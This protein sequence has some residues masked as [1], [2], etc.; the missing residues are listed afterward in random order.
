MNYEQTIRDWIDERM[1]DGMSEEEAQKSVI[2]DTSKLYIAATRIRNRSNKRTV[3]RTIKNKYTQKDIEDLREHGTKW[4]I[5]HDGAIYSSCGF[6]DTSK[7]KAIETDGYIERIGTASVLKH[8]G[9]TVQ[10][11]RG[12]GSLIFYKMNCELLGL[13]V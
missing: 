6:L 9:I 12:Q 10:S 4:G 3:A 2:N 5:K 13:Q 1:G 8:M 7:R 11:E